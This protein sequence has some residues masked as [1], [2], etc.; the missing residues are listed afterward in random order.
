MNKTN[1]MAIQ[2]K[3]KAE[4]MGWNVRIMLDQSDVVDYAT[5]VAW[6]PGSNKA[7]YIR[8]IEEHVSIKGWCN[9]KKLDG[10][11]DYHNAL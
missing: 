5:V 7:R 11:L 9:L 3:S 6:A 1:S 10:L 2:A 4:A 8:F